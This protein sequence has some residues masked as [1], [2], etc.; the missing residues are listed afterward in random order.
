M[1]KEKLKE[2]SNTKNFPID[3]NKLYEEKVGGVKY[4]APLINWK[5]LSHITFNTAD[6]VLELNKL[7]ELH[8][9]RKYPVAGNKTRY[10]YK[11]M[12]LTSFKDHDDKL[13]GSFYIY[14][15]NNQLIGNEKYVGIQQ[16]E[17]FLNLNEEFENDFERTEACTSFFGNILDQF[18]APIT[19]V[20]L[21][22]LAPGGII[23]PH[24][25]YPYTYGIK[26]HAYLETN[27]DVWCEVDGER[28]QIPSNGKFVWMDVSKPHSVINLGD[29]PR[30]TLCVNLNPYS[31]DKFKGRILEDILDEL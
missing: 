18:S 28:F 13:S 8:Q 4:S 16:E 12:S 30:T 22:E 3:R 9:F 21:L 20:R 2:L 6:A 25:D 27:D 10:Y 26:L 23:P 7:K 24:I 11:G 29:K 15:K 19:R 1:I 31:L 14:D 17:T 5:E